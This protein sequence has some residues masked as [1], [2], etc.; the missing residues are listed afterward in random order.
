MT[1]SSG[2]NTLG[3]GAVD[4]ILHRRHETAV[5]VLADKRVGELQAGVTAQRVGGPD[6]RSSAAKLG[7]RSSGAKQLR[8]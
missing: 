4:A 3:G 7:G 1:R 5:H 2:E 6:T 8:N